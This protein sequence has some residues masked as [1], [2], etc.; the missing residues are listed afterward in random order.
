M[1]PKIAR[2]A[3]EWI[4]ATVV[5][6]RIAFDK[7]ATW[8]AQLSW[9]KFFLFALLLVIAGAIV[10]D[11]LF[12]SPPER[13]ATVVKKDKPGLHSKL[14]RTDD[15]HTLTTDDGT[16][17]RI[18]SSGL[19]I[20]KNTQRQVPSVSKTSNGADDS[21]DMENKRVPM[22]GDSTI[23]PTPALPSVPSVPSVPPVPPVPSGSPIPPD[24]ANPQAL[25]PRP[26]VSSSE[27]HIRLPPEISREV[28]DAIDGAVDEAAQ[29][30][31]SVAQK[32]STTW[33]K[34]F[35]LL[36]IVGLF[37]TKALMG[38]KKRAE[39][40]AQ[41]AHAAAERET[42]HRQVT[43]AKM[44][45]MQAQVE[46][47]F[48]FNTLASV[49]YLIET[50]PPRASAMQRRLI[51]Y[52]RAVLPQIRD[53]AASTTLGREGGMV[54]AY[55]DLL[56]MRME[57]RLTVDF[58]IP[59]GLRSA[60]FPPMMLQSLVENAI[61]HGIEPKAEGGTLK[62]SAEV[63]DNRLR[64]TVADNGL[65]FGAVTSDGTGLG[66]QSIRDRLKLLYGNAAALEISACQPT[67]VSA[68][69]EVP[70]Q[71]AAAQTNGTSPQ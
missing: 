62:V 16:N 2:I 39:A 53:A 40:Q 54:R 67:G 66:L 55:L 51:Q 47:H 38:G 23:A 13:R 64:V 7:T 31:V 26:V 45:V 9:F 25:P 22:A 46:P 4:T 11:T 60:A 44:Q 1:D 63:V 70:Y 30:R 20:T 49:E 21:A 52:L 29:D 10:Q 41:V 32:T 69:I 50:D 42:L 8:V 17:I 65:G 36:L 68:S 14:L 27:L 57:E 24:A 34:N 48:L 35:V 18:D 58:Q 71:L 61:K 15:V 6:M 12:S 5:F 43:E 19:Y 33:F 3:Q 28:S 59:D 56:K 37:G